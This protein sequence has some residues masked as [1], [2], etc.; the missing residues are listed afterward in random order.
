MFDRQNAS[1]SACVV[2]RALRCE[3]VTGGAAHQ[4]CDVATTPTKWATARRTNRSFACSFY[5]KRVN[6]DQRSSKKQRLPRSSADALPCCMHGRRGHCLPRHRKSDIKLTLVICHGSL[7]SPSAC[8][9]RRT[10]ANVAPSNPTLANRATIQL[11]GTS[12]QR[13]LHK[14]RSQ[15]RCAPCFHRSA[16]RCVQGAQHF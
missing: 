3:S 5:S 2:V 10:S 1:S 12:V 13:V 16:K 9:R 7:P 11:A 15:R 8:I 6:T 14:Q 4:I